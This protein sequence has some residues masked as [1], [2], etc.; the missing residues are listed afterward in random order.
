MKSVKSFSLSDHTNEP[1]VTDE[2]EDTAPYET[3]DAPA[4]TA[5]TA[6]T[7]QAVAESSGDD[8]AS[9]TVIE[10]PDAPAEPV[11]NN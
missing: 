1:P 8:A 10:V 6:Q 5:E 4:D 2:P 7:T 3:S 11:E 9:T